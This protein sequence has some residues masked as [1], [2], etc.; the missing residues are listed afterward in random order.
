V[1]RELAKYVTTLSEDTWHPGDFISYSGLE[2][3]ELNEMIRAGLSPRA[4]IILAQAGRVVAWMNGRNYVVPSDIQE[5]FL[6]T[7][8]HRFFLTRIATKR[9]T[10]LAREILA[11]IIEKIPAPGTL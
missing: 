9:R 6:D 3:K 5:I 7:C 2:G 11:K 1:S 8:N 4:E 10:D